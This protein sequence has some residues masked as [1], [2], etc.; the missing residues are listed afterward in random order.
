MQLVSRYLSWSV[1]LLFHINITV[2]EDGYRYMNISLLSIERYDFWAGSKPFSLLNL[3]YT[4][5]TYLAVSAF[6]AEDFILSE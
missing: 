4:D 6:I 2:T 5:N 3:Y 1:I